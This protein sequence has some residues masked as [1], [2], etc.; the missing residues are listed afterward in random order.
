M[1]TYMTHQSLPISEHSLIQDVRS[2]IGELRTS[3]PQGSRVKSSVVL[4]KEKD[5]SKTS[6]RSNPIPETS[7]WPQ[8]IAL[9]WYDPDTSCLRMSQGSLLPDIS[10]ES[11]PTLPDSVIYF[12]RKLFPLPRW[13][14]PTNDYDGGLW[15]T[16]Q[17][18]DGNMRQGRD[19]ISHKRNLER[20]QLASVALEEEAKRKKWPTPRESEWKG[21]GPVGSKSHKHMDDRNYLCAKVLNYP[22]PKAKDRGQ[23]GQNAQGGPDLGEVVQGQLNPTWVSWLMGWPLGITEDGEITDWTDLRPLRELIW[24]SWEIDPADD[25]RIPRIAT[26][27]P[28]RV[29]RLKCIGNGQVPLCAATAWRILNGQAPLGVR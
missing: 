19:T 13:V 26:N 29:S 23:R 25:G 18:T 21:T 12:E 11:Y 20:K 14:P 5:E 17:T 2:F 4:A 28:D 9:A 27:I 16:P 3:S 15:P 8:G 7:G 1:G 22:T 24:L 6:K 10:G